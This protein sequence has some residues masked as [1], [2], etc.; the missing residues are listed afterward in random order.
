VNPSS[1]SG[2]ICFEPGFPVCLSA[3]DQ[4]TVVAAARGNFLILF[5]F[6]GPVCPARLFPGPKSLDLAY[7]EAISRTSLT[8]IPVVQNGFAWLA[9]LF[10]R[11]RQSRNPL[12]H[13][14]D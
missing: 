2:S 10:G 3:T 9:S 6:P 4:Y 13:A 12:Q 5:Q 1:R 8:S 11:E 14:S 7:L